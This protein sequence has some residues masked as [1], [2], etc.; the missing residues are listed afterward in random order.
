MNYKIHVHK[1]ISAYVYGKIIYHNSIRYAVIGKQT[2][3]RYGIMSYNKNLM[4]VAN[5]VITYTVDNQRSVTL[6]T[7][8]K[9][10]CCS[11]KKWCK[12][13]AHLLIHNNSN[14]QIIRT[15]TDFTKQVTT[16]INWKKNATVCKAYDR[17][18]VRR[19][20]YYLI[21]SFQYFHYW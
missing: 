18:C 13:R 8:I 10:A 1:L 5:I 3:H 16:K 9:L 7:I 21:I 20:N 17:F 2:T 4:K 12:T 15:K 6:R 11:G 19:K 14:F